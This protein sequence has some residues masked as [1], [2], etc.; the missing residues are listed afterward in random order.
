MY[1][2]SLVTGQSGLAVVQLFD[3]L[4][5][6]GALAQPL[7]VVVDAAGQLV[8]DTAVAWFV[9]LAWARDNIAP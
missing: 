5:V 2:Q 6:G 3:H 9:L 8:L 1:T 4:F 7:E